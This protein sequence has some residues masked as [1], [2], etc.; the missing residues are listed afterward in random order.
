MI[1]TIDEFLAVSRFHALVVELQSRQLDA[2]Q[3]QQTG[4]EGSPENSRPYKRMWYCADNRQLGDFLGKAEQDRQK[5]DQRQNSFH[6][7]DTE[8]F[9]RR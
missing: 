1:F 2:D 8:L 7:I 6:Q 9:Q 3:R 4:P 5:G